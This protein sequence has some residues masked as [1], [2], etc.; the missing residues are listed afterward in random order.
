[1]AHHSSAVKQIRVNRK[2]R[3]L[4]KSNRTRVK[5]EI[6]KFRG[7]IEEGKTEEAKAGLPKLMSTVAHSVSLK[8]MHKK[9]ASR[10]ISRLAKAL[11]RA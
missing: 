1:M 3:K 8:V 11:N 9:T 2:A 4:N 5:S 7:Q 6:K 10:R